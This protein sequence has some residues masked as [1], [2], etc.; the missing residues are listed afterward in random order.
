MVDKLVEEAAQAK[1]DKRVAREIA[2]NDA[3][4]KQV[5]AKR[6]TH[7]ARFKTPEPGGATTRWVEFA[8][9]K[10]GES[11]ARAKAEKQ[12]GTIS[13]WTVVA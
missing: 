4:F 8:R 10:D 7:C 13:D 5:C 12:F 3:H 11:N 2:K 1:E 9:H 6:G